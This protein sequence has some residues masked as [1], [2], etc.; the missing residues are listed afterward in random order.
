MD[1]GT[2]N[3]FVLNSGGAGVGEGFQPLLG[4]TDIMVNLPGEAQQVPK[5]RLKPRAFNLF[6]ERFAPP[7]PVEN[8]EISINKELC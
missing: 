8:D 4:Q 6:P 2:P 1:H 7:C 5:G 3:S